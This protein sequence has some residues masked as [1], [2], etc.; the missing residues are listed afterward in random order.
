[1][2]K[3]HYKLENS[4]D[5][6][7]I[8]INGVMDTDLRIENLNL[9][10]IE[11]VVIN[12]DGVTGINSLGTK[13]WV[14][15]LDNNDFPSVS[16][17]YKKCRPGVVDQM[18]MTH[19]FMPEHVEVESFYVDYMCEKCEHEDEVLFD[20]SKFDVNDIPDQNCSE[21]SATMEIEGDDEH[22]FLFLESA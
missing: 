8:Q 4:K 5:T 12:F 11:T 21:C 13:N 19:A 22:Y 14:N 7:E 18:N 2:A 1:V 6:I 20:T 15:F 9:L 3:F 17:I 16:L 10:S